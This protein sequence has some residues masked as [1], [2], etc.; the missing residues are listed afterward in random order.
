MVSL[1]VTLTVTDVSLPSARPNAIKVCLTARLIEAMFV[2]IPASKMAVGN[3]E[4]I[5]V[6]IETSAPSKL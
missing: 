6:S 4:C 1:M 2:A 3:K 5:L